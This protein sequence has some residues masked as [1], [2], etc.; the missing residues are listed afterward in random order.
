M[1]EE[2]LEQL[3]NE[4]QGIYVARGDDV[5][6]LFVFTR[7]E[8]IGIGAGERVVIIV[9][10]EHIPPVLDYSPFMFAGN[11]VTA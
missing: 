5:P 1:S 7:N 8:N 3:A 10:R 11:M 6:R 9:R 2:L 4:M